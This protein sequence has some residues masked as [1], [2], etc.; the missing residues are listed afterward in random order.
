MLLHKPLLPMSLLQVVWP[1]AY[2]KTKYN[3]NP[4]HNLPLLGCLTTMSNKLL[5]QIT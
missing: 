4:N 5:V 3:L 1:K 2:P